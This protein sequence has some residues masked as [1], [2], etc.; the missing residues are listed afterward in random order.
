MV[1]SVFLKSILVP[2]V[3]FIYNVNQY[4]KEIISYIGSVNKIHDQV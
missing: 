3:H 2:P 4:V 1:C